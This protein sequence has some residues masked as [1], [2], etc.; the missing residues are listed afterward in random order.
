MALTGIDIAAE[1]DRPWH[2]ARLPQLDGAHMVTDGGIETVLIFHEQVELPEFAAFD[3]L[4]SDEG[5]ERLRR[6]FRRYADLA[7]AHELGLV[8]ESPTWRASPDWGRA[9]GYSLDELAGANRRAIELMAE[10]REEYRDRVSP[11]VISGC[12]GPQ[13]D[14]YNPATL[15]TAEEAEAYHAVQVAVFAGTAAD[16]VCAI[17]M[18]Y[19]EEAIGIVRA[20]RAHE[21]PVAIS[22]TL[23]TDGR[24]PSGEPLA[25]AIARVDDL[26]DGG[27]DYH[28]LNCA[29]PEHIEGAFEAPGDWRSRIL[30]LRA[31]ASRKSHA[32]LDESPELD[33]GDP[34]EL[35]GQYVELAEMFPELRVLGGCCGTDHRHVG[36]ICAAWTA[37][38]KP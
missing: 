29:H 6:Y 20:A 15:L 21:M 17:T 32:E 10:I 13:G 8:L 30:G 26:T 35:G 34:V 11:I 24:L 3:Q 36:E 27:P 4:A 14:G 2:R 19:A 31:N 5:T 7:A 16:M 22:F 25:E 23:E 37:A 9:L 38:R 1:R 28:M 33:E 12:I 18:C